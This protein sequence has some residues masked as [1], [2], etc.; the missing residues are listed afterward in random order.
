M[1]R[2]GARQS[3]AQC[4]PNVSLHRVCGFAAWTKRLS[5]IPQL[6]RLVGSRLVHLLLKHDG[7]IEP[8]YT[9]WISFL[10]YSICGV[11]VKE[12]RLLPGNYLES[13][14]AIDR[15]CYVPL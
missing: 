7:G 1:L 2:R 3:L 11:L 4:E 9:G 14:S 15:A 10:S 8:G 12:L 13:C 6:C 5:N